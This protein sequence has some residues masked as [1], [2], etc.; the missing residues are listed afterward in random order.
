MPGRQPLIAAVLAG[1]VFLTGTSLVFTQGA[2]GPLGVADATARK[3]VVD[4]I[5]HDAIRMIRD[6]AASTTSEIVT[7]VRRAYDWM[8]MSARGPATTAAFRVGQDVC[9]LPRVRGRLRQTT[10][11]AE[12]RRRR[13]TRRAW[14]PEL[15][16]MM[17]DDQ[18]A[19]QA[20]A[21]KMA[22]SDCLRKIARHSSLS[23]RCRKNSSPTP[24]GLRPCEARSKRSGRQTPPAATRRPSTGRPA[25]LQ[26]TSC[27]SGSTSSGFSV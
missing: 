25:T 6:D 16:K 5:L 4:A 7:A 22:E 12:T 14:T 1:V 11:G 18:R 24:R 2:A 17:M 8:P 15:K 21:R 23:S 20:E 26:I 3:L 27:S 10:R 19:A 13:Q 9:Q